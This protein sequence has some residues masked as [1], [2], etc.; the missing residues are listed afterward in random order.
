MRTCPLTK[1]VITENDDE[2]ISS[3]GGGPD[4]VAKQHKADKHNVYGVKN[5]YVLYELT[6]DGLDTAEVWGSSPHA[7]TIPLNN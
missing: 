3:H 7:P 4:K 6:A 1:L 2:A 5:D